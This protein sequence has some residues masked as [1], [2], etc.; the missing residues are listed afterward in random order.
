MSRCHAFGNLLVCITAAP[1]VWATLT[2]PAQAMDAR[3]FTDRSLFGTASRWPLVIINSLH[4][5]HMAAW[6]KLNAAEYF[7]HLVFIPTLGFAGQVFTW[8]A[9]GNFQA[10][11]ISGLPGGLDYLLLALVKDGRFDKMREKQWSANLNVWCRCPGILATTVLCYQSLLYGN[12]AGVPTYAI[13]LQ[14]LLPPWN[15]LYYCKQSVANFAVHHML[16]IYSE[17]ET[18]AERI[19]MRTSKLAGE[20][21][22]V[23]DVKKPQLAS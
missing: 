15:A 7:H 19:K 5:Y 18:I 20:E 8:G 1:S 2:D 11:F 21:V 4:L 14:L 9:L 22:M 13:A 23:W 17:D 6:T 3:V 16:R 10:F 12:H